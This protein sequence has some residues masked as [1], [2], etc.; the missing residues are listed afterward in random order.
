MYTPASLDISA[1]LPP[2]DFPAMLEILKKYLQSVPETPGIEHETALIQTHASAVL[3][4][5]T[6]VYKLK[7]PKNFGFFDYSTPLL[8]RHFCQQEVWL[9]RVLAPHVYLGVAPVLLSNS[10]QFRFGSTYTPEQV[11]EPGAVLDG[12]LVVDYAVVMVRLPDA[13]ASEARVRANTASPQLLGVIAHAIAVFHQREL[14]LLGK[15]YTALTG[16]SEPMTSCERRPGR[17]S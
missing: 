17:L 8:R 6:R 1:A 12:D 2:I 7:K 13:A 9:N 4:N 16:T 3:L 15:E 14:T 11:P 5:A 10:E